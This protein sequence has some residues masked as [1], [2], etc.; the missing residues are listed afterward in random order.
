V[1]KIF[2]KDGGDSRYLESLSLFSKQFLSITNRLRFSLTICN[3]TLP[4]LPKLLHRFLNLTSI[5]FTH[6]SGDLDALLSQISCFPLKLT[7]LNLS[8][9]P[10]IPTKG[11]QAFSQKITTLTSLKCSNIVHLRNY[12]LILISKC[13]P[14]LEE[15]DLSDPVDVDV[16]GNVMPLPRLRKV[17]LSGHSRINKLFL[18]NLCK[19]CEFLEEIVML[20]CKFITIDVVSLFDSAIRES[21]LLY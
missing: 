2:L 15:L 11:L 8:N 1:F 19:N 16:L 9:Q 21:S 20:E 14:F 13:F 3:P 12:D 5:D 6:F 10:T 4:F 7:S 18:L 17:N